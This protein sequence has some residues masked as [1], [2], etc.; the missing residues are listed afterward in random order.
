MKKPK[1]TEQ[2]IAVALH[3][4]ETAGKAL[5]DPSCQARMSASSKTHHTGSTRA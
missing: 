3:Q 2:Q 4:A 5:P 1:F